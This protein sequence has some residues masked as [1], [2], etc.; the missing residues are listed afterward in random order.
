[1]YW[2]SRCLWKKS[3]NCKITRQTYR[4][5]NNF[6]NSPNNEWSIKKEWS[7]NN[8]GADKTAPTNEQK[9][10]TKSYSV[11]DTNRNELVETNDTALQQHLSKNSKIT[12]STNEYIRTSL[13]GKVKT[14]VNNAIN[15]F[16]SFNYK[17][18]SLI[19]ND[20][21]IKE[22]DA[23]VES[24]TNRIKSQIQDAYNQA[25][26]IAQKELDEQEAARQ[27]LNENKDG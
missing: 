26:L 3:R 20:I 8:N 10:F 25:V 5:F 4:S 7:A 9:E 23:H 13:A 18:E 16:K 6:S 11:F 22:A 1:M 24:E 21:K 14:F 15:T 2:R 12:E 19:E 27:K 17:S